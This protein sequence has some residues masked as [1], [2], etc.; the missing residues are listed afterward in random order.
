MLCSFRDIDSLK[1]K[2]E[3]DVRFLLKS[4]FGRESLS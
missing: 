1:L 2:R 3:E 4:G